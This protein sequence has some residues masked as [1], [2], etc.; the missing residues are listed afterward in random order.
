MITSA[1][2]GGAVWNMQ[3][4]WPI[5]AEYELVDVNPDYQRTIVGRSKRD[6]VWLMA[7]KPTLS[8]Q[9]YEAAI[10]RIAQLGYDVAQVRRVPQ[11][12]ALTLH[13]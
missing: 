5:H 6:Y 2:S 11:R 1:G 10:E 8:E 4:V 9:S 7:R 13:Y 12:S 3:F